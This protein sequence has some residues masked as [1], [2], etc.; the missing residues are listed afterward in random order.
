MSENAA[1]TTAVETT[2][3]STAEQ[4]QQ[5]AQQQTPESHAPSEPQRSAEAG[6]QSFDE[7]S[8]EEQENYLKDNFLESNGAD[9]ED[10]DQSSNEESRENPSEEKAEEEAEKEDESE[11]SRAKPQYTTEQFLSL[12]PQQVDASRLP[13]A[14]KIVHD[15]YMKYFNDQIAP[16]MKE[17]QELRAFRDKVANGQIPG[18][19]EA[20][21]QTSEDVRQKAIDFAEAAK[22]EAARRL[23][24]DVIDEFDA[25]HMAVVTQVATE[26]TNKRLQEESSREQTSQ[27]LQ[28][29]R[30]N[31]LNAEK[32]MKEEFGSDFALIDQWAVQEMENLPMK[33]VNKITADLRSGDTDKIIAVFRMFG[34]RYKAHIGQASA[35]PQEKQ[36]P[37]ALINGSGNQQK[38]SKSWGVKDFSKASSDDQVK[39]LIDAGLV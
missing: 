22:A 28:Q 7:M 1:E 9:D 8:Y 26:M 38:S 4:G 15:R 3:E 32:I 16:A 2:T 37:P 12:D 17:L 27:K 35:K 34:E 30:Q 18:Q 33:T 25:G 11:S 39:M 5:Q 10:P 29:G 20:E 21:K 14:A 23:G 13:D 36:N 6:S 31:I 19:P 24:V